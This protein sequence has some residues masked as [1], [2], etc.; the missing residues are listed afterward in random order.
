MKHARRSQGDVGGGV[1]TEHR[2]WMNAKNTKNPGKSVE[3]DVPKLLKLENV[4]LH[5]QPW[6]DQS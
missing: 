4:L 6:L 1:G 3:I 2:P 5:H